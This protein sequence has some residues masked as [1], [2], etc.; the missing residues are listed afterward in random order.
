MLPLTDLIY[1]AGNQEE[2]FAIVWSSQ[3]AQDMTIVY[4]A[5]DSIQ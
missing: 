3:E 1:R 5:F 4:P 2:G